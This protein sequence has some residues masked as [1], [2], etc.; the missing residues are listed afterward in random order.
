VALLL[1]LGLALAGHGIDAPGAGGFV[2]RGNGPARGGDLR[3]PASAEAGLSL[4]EG[5]VVA[6]GGASDD[7][8]LPG[9]GYLISGPGAGRG[10]ETYAR[11]EVPPGVT[12]SLAGTL[13]V[14]L[15]QVKRMTVQANPNGVAAVHF[16]SRSN[17]AVN[18]EDG[19]LQV[20][21]PDTLQPIQPPEGGVFNERQI[22]LRDHLDVM[23]R[24]IHRPFVENPWVRPLGEAAL[25]TFS[26]DVDTA[27]YSIVRRCLV[28]QGRLPPPGALRIEEMV[29]YFPYGYEGPANGDPFAV[30][31][32]AASCPWAPRHRLVRIALQGRTVADEVRPPANVVFLVDV[33]GSMQPD[34]KLPLAKASIAL[35]AERLDARDRISI[36]VYAGAAGLV[37]PPTSGA[38]RAAVKA[39]LDGLGAGGSTAGGAGIELAYRVAAENFVPGGINRVVLATDGDWNVGVSDPSALHALIAEKARTGVFLTVLGYGMDNLRDDTLETLADRGNGNYGYVDG[40]AEARKILVDEGMSTLHAIAKD[41]KIQV[42]WN[43]AKVAGYRLLGYENRALAARDFADDAKDAG[44]IGAGHAVTALY[45]VVPAGVEV[46]GAPVD[47]LRFQ[48]PGF[49]TGHAET[50]LVKLRWKEPEGTV[51]TARE[52]PFTDGGASFEGADDDFRFAAA[53]AAFGMVLRDSANAGAADLPLVRALAAGA[54]ADDPGGWRREFLG[55]VDR[56][57]ALKK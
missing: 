40:L 22:V 4:L 17:L 20:F 16:G 35:L 6:V 47:G 30:R 27:A 26:I 44:E 53:V 49:P 24:E 12:V 36:V 23:S 7:P 13:P 54:L 31:V 41:V 33:S 28:E 48:A 37:L 14:S 34:N 57:A 52:I 8:A 9:I 50:L 45:E 38:D 43:P 32:D 56:A 46:P 2:A 55:L 5:S 51:S 42:E 21:N 11:S 10:G 29:N 25:S 1:A 18:Q 39:A 3:H 15:L 19:E